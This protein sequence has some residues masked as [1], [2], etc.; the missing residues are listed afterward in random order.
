MGQPARTPC[1]VMTTVR[2]IELAPGLG[3]QALQPELAGLPEQVWAYL[4]CSNSETKM[5]SGRRARLSCPNAAA[6]S[7]DPRPRAQ[8]AASVELHSSCR[9]ETR[10]LEL[11]SQINQWVLSPGLQPPK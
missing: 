9:R 7:A 10:R 6:A 1:S 8:D 3:D 4:P 2:Y 11:A 5:P